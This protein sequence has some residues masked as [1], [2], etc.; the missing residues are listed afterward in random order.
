[1]KILLCA[2]AALVAVLSIRAQTPETVKPECTQAGL[3]FATDLFGEALLV[4]T[5]SG[6]IVTIALSDKTAVTRAPH[7]LGE[8]PEPMSIQV[9]Q[10]G[11][12]V[13]AYLEGDSK[14][15]AR[16][17]VMPRTEIS[18]KQ[19]EFL[20]EWHR[21]SI[22]GDI[23]ELDSAR[24]TMV[25]A[26]VPPTAEMKPVRVKLGSDVKF[27]TFPPKATNVSDAI[28]F[29][30][31]DLH[32]G[33]RVYVWGNRPP[34]ESILPAQ[35]VAKDGFRVITGNILSISP[36]NSI[37]QIREFGTGRVLDVKLTMEQIYRT[38][39]AITTPTK[40]STPSGVP[41]VNLG[42]SDLQPG[43]VVMV[44]GKT[45]EQ[46]SQALGL[47]LITEFG[48]FGIAPNDLSGQ[49]TWILR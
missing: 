15:A 27:R 49:L 18:A 42:F 5:P 2:T 41:M 37:V 28:P 1:M 40:I 34:G 23:R 7:S 43:D 6:S 21:G 48:T 45:Q 9:I 12:L 22:Y 26:P 17:T 32:V 46:G 39:P 3:V 16:L 38:A 35:I 24:D 14:T 25:V 8:P 33:D 29:R 13:C 19:R 11:D 44:I 10:A 20:T 31:E 47:I 36:M 4:K 30:I